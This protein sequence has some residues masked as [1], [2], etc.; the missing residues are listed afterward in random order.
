MAKI[1]SANSKR[2]GFETVRLP[3]KELFI[4]DS[5][6]RLTGEEHLDWFDPCDY[7]YNDVDLVHTRL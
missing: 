6:W 3:C 5:I 4:K 2:E 7:T 1:S